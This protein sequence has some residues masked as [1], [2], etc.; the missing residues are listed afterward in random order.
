MDT[1][2]MLWE[3]RNFLESRTLTVSQCQKVM[4][5]LCSQ[6]EVLTGDIVTADCLRSEVASRCE[7]T[8]ITDGNVIGRIEKRA[9]ELFYEYMT[10]RYI[11]DIINEAVNDAFRENDY[12]RNEVESLCKEKGITD[13]NA[14]D[15]IEERA[16]K[17]F[18]DEDITSDFD[19]ESDIIN[20]AVSNVFNKLLTQ[21]KAD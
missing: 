1:E 18:F 13:E 17:L 6:K 19:E 8:G 3:I 5:S 11:S 20:K 16:A 2:T 21:K 15:K 7:E 9:A 12:L 10:Y 4:D 14:I